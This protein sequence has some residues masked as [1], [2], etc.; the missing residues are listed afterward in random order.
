MSGK[1][2]VD[3]HVV[4]VGG[5]SGIGR[6][7]A[8][9][10]RAAGARVTV[11]SRSERRL[12]AVAAE[13]GVAT[14]P[15]DV[16]DEES[17]RALFAA[18]G[19]LDH[20]VVCPGEMANGSVREVGADAVRACLDTKIVGQL[21]AVRHAHPGLAADGS[22]VLL[23]GAGGYKPFAGMSVT[24]AANVGI[25]AMGRSLA[26]ELAPVRVNVLVA[27]L[28]DTPL[29][30][31]LPAEDRAAFFTATAADT[32]VGRIGQPEDIAASVLHLLENSFVNGA[33]LHVDGGALL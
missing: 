29:W 11:A 22:I 32:P 21:L 31:F 3:R 7:V 14:H 9:G 33:L 10:A 18:A 20:L 28:V 12:A 25:G 27:G 2:L 1:E 26:L 5:S 17:V 13:L 30:D 8:A 4:V 24:A 6:A 15:V 16:T 19:E 23:A